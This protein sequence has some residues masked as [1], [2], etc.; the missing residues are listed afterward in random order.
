MPNGVI[1]YAPALIHTVGL[2]KNTD[3]RTYYANH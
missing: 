2:F 3:N 1:Q